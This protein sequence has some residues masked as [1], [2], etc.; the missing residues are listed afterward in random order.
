[1][2]KPDTMNRLFDLFLVFL[3]TKDEKNRTVLKNELVILFKELK[4]DKGISNF[5]KEKFADILEQYTIIY[6]TDSIIEK[7]EAEE[8]VRELIEEIKI[9]TEK[10]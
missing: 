9:D 4:E 6:S 10:K 3:K 1:M 5:A 2:S 8:R 7:C